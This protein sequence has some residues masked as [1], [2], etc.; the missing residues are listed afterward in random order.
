MIS[1]LPRT[2]GLALLV[3]L[4]AAVPVLGGCA[5]GEEAANKVVIGFM[6][7][8]TGPAAA[9]CK[10]LHKALTDH[11][12]MVKEDDPIP[13]VDVELITFDTRMEYSRV[14]QGYEWLRG[15]GADIF[16]NFNPIMQEMILENHQQDG[17]ATICF[18][19]TPELISQDWS[20]SFSGHYPW[21]AEAII[22]WI[23]EDWAERPTGRP[24]KVGLV[25]ISGYG[26]TDQVS[27]KLNQLLEDGTYEFELA[28]QVGLPTT[29]YW[30]AEVDALDESDIIIVNSVGPQAASFVRDAVAKGYDGALI[31]TS[32]AFLG[33]WDLIKGAVESL[34]DIDGALSIHAH[35]VWT[36]DASFMDR[37][38][39]SLSRFRE[40]EAEEL[41]KG[42]S[43]MTGI[44]LG[45]ILV[46][47]IRRAVAEAGADE[48]DAGALNDAMASIDI[49]MT[50]EGF[51]ESWKCHG[52]SNVL[53]R[54]VRIVQYWSSDDAWHPYPGS[55]WFLPPSL[56][57]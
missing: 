51:G 34:D 3:V 19:S 14:N 47:T 42:T 21:E 4:L 46:D 32:I 50:A 37:V 35:T 2:V 38:E 18:V 11:L 57:Q 45:M 54:M 13:G 7:D 27:E 16:L 29:G 36:E 53:H 17:I 40:S 55:E 9:T 10:E 12:K 48:V 20:Y 41:M 30:T 39:A 15:R 26:S 49:D 5:G 6:G 43:Y 22:K 33:F 1:K 25:G 52:G 44:E 56:E 23:T 8:F 28:E 24:A 31:G